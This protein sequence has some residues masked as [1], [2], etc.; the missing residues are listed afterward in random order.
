M[1]SF[2]TGLRQADPARLAELN[3]LL[4]TELAKDK[5]DLPADLKG[6]PH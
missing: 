3:A 2:L 5:K 1:I 6:L 4:A